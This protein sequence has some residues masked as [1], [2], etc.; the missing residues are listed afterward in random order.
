M[1][2]RELNYVDMAD[3]KKAYAEGKNITELLRTKQRVNIN[4]S[5]IIEVAYDLQAGTYIENVVQDP[6]K[7]NLYASE[8]AQI[9]DLHLNKEHTILDVGTGELTTLSLVMSALINKPK[10]VYAFDI[11]WSRIYK[12]ITFAKSKIGQDYKRIK[13]FVADIL[14]I[15]LPEKSIDISISSHALE[16]NGEKVKELLAAIF[17][18]TSG[19]LILFEPCYEI[20][21]K[22]GRDRMDKLGYIKN[23]ERIVPELGG[24]VVDKILIKNS[25]NPLNPTVGFIITP[26]KHNARKSKINN[27]LFTVPG[28]DFLLRKKEGFYYSNEIGLCYPILKNVP[29]LKSNCSILA[30]SFGVEK[31]V[32]SVRNPAI[33]QT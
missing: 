18:V 21:S 11:S 24:E 33:D 26:T 5:E 12:G 3:A 30:T 8:I 28:T 23:V 7:A 14:E 1:S 29:V 4:T 9:L 6:E 17:R 25:I 27:F 2:N 13:P 19:K 31:N 16:P 15:P 22:E 20:N 32:L 10:V